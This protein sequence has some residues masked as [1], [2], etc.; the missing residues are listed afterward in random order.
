MDGFGGGPESPRWT[1]D[2]C[3]LSFLKTE[4]PSTTR[5]LIAELR[6]MKARY[7]QDTDTL[8]LELRA[9]E[10]VD[11]RD[12]DHDTILDYDADGNIVGITLEHARSRIGG[13]R[14]E[15]ETV[16]A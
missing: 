1:I 6:P 7:F 14:I 2:F 10:V 16:P 8:Y 9:S 13:E 5:F 3:G 4:R 15:F 11:T 12:L